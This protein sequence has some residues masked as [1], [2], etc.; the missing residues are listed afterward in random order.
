MVGW[1]CES[2]IGGST[3]DGNVVMKWLEVQISGMHCA[4]CANAIR[5]A[6]DRVEGVASC[7][8]RLNQARV[9]FDGE[10]CGI[11]EIVAAIRGSGAFEV[12][13]FSTEGE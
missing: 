2:S 10:R 3:S 6:V 4:G 7:E 8:V 5:Q 13:G 1:C 9:S 12:T 11:A